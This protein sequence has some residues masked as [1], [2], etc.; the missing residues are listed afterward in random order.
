[1][2]ALKTYWLGGLFGLAFWILLLGL[3]M[4]AAT[5]DTGFFVRA[6]CATIATPVTNA[7]ACLQTTTTGGRT[8]GQVYVWNGSAYTQITGAGGAAPVDATYI[9]QTANST[10]TNEQNLAALSTGIL[11]G[12]TGTGAVSIGA[13]GTDFVGPGAITTS[14]L[15]QVTGKLLGR[16]T[17]ATGA[18]EEITV[19]T[20][21]SLSGTTLNATAGAGGYATIQEEGSD[22]TQRTKVNFIGSAVTCVDNVGATRT[23]C[24]ISSGGAGALT[25]VESHTFT[26][27]ATSFTFSGLD[28]DTDGQYLLI[29]RLIAN[30][31]TNTLNLEP[32]ALASNLLFSRNFNGGQNTDLTDWRLCDA[33]SASTTIHFALTVYGSKS[34]N[35]VASVRNVN[36][37]ITQ[38][39]GGGSGSNFILNVGGTWNETAT[40]LTSLRLISNVASGIGNGSYAALYKYTQ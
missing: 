34:I 9:T 39:I 22:L 30:G 35:S 10:L 2:K 16:N 28:G 23:D 4:G 24:T 25:L 1:M 32:N 6:N 36:G 11:K 40:N 27:N 17:A 8:A 19:G 20:N 15:T 31:G 14:G 18:V 29:G 5:P 26:A 38:V 12:T 13:A 3:A 33:C 37:S 21:L 7:T